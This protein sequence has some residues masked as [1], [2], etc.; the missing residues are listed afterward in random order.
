MLFSELYNIAVNTVTFVGLGGRSPPKDPPLHQPSI[1]ILHNTA[2]I[3]L[4]AEFV[5]SKSYLIDYKHKIEARQEILVKEITSVSFN[6][7]CLD[8]ERYSADSF[9]KGTCYKTKISHMSAVKILIIDLE[10]IIP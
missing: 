10:N 3:F 7:S 6:R 2:I 8:A 5:E 4:F 1:A 9:F